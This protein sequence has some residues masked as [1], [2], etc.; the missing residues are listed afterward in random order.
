MTV[1]LVEF[2]TDSLLIM[3]IALKAVFKSLRDE[4]IEGMQ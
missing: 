1:Y 2:R 4:G 3:A